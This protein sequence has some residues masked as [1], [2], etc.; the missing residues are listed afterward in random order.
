MTVRVES[1]AQQSRPSVA[2]RARAYVNLAKPHV[3]MLLLAVT[4]TTMIVADKGWPSVGLIV[5]TLTG[6][7]LAAASANAINCYVDRDIDGLMGRTQRRAVPSGRIEPLH[8][9]WFGLGCA[10]AS[11]AVFFI[12][13]NVLSGLL[14]LSGILFYVLVYTM[15]LKRT[16]PQNIVIGG[17]AGGVPALVGWAAVTHTLAWPAVVLFAIIFFWTPPHFWALSLLIKKDYE[18]AGVPMLPIVRGDA[19]TQRQIF[20]YTLLLIPVS[21]LLL[22]GGTA[23]LLYLGLAV[24][25]G[26][27]L[28]VLAFRLLRTEPST[29]PA[30][31]LASRLFW[32]SNS[33]LAL[34]FVALA[35]DRLVR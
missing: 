27:P 30:A 23:G 8:A 25:L 11:Q 3:T 21:L 5:A 15:W 13:V 12:F 14:A 22:I 17:A 20:L 28:V 29:P 4:V 35:V 10:V 16:T 18:R 33:Y 24:A 2:D 6:G 26:V 1:I 7:V 19:E 34:L 32:Y 9:L 31:H